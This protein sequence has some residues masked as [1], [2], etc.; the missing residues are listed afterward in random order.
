MLNITQLAIV[1]F[2]LGIEAKSKEPKAKSQKQRANSQKSKAKSQE[3]RAKSQE[4]K[5]KSKKPRAKSQKPK[6]NLFQYHQL[7]TNKLLPSSQRIIINT[8]P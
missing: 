8:T 1:N 2:A 5:A 3:Q 6:A 4:P 7:L